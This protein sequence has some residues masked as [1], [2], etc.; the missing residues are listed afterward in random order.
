VCIPHDYTGEFVAR[1][2]DILETYALP[3]DPQIPLICMDEPPYRLLGDVVAS[4][5]ME[6]GQ[7]E[8]VDYEY[9]RGGTC[10]AFLCFVNLWRGGDM[11]RLCRG[12]PSLIGRIKLSGC[13]LS[14]IR[15]LKRY[16]L[17]WII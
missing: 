16:V 7:V 9:E 13:W 14:F 2:E 8:R 11:W 17:L 6:P 12:V 5:P 15:E 10:I 4:I 3:Y 1:M